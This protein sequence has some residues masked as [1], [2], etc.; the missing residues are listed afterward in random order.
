MYHPR[1]A[2]VVT[3]ALSEEKKIRCLPW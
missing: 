1:K 2:I 3:Y